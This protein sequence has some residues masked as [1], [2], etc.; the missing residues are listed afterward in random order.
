MARHVLQDMSSAVPWW[1]SG[2]FTLAALA[3][4]CLVTEALKP[5]TCG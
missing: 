4:H 3:Y 1:G 5:G 2:L